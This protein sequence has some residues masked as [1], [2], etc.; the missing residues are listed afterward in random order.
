[1]ECGGSTYRY[2]KRN[3]LMVQIKIQ[4]EIDIMAEGGKILATVLN[5]DELNH[6]PV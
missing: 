5:P 4:T 6:L 2:F 1:M 3:E